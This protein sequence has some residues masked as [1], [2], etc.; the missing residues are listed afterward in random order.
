MLSEVLDCD[1]TVITAEEKATGKNVHFVDDDGRTVL[2]RFIKDP[3]VIWEKNIKQFLSGSGSHVMAD[4]VIITGGPFMHFGLGNWM[5]KRFG[6][7]VILDY[8]DPFA[9]NPIFHNSRI[10]RWVKLFFEKRFNKNCD[11][12]ITVNRYCADLI[13]GFYNKPNAII[14]NGFDERIALHSAVRRTPNGNRLIY[15]GKFYFD[16]EPLQKAT[17]NLASELVYAGADSEFLNKK[18]SNTISLGLLDHGSIFEQ[19][20]QSN[21]G[22]VQIAGGFSHLSTTKIFDYMR[23]GLRILVISEDHINKGALVEILS[24]YDN[25]CW[26]LN[27]E[28]AITSAINKLINSDYKQPDSNY[29]E[30][31]SRRSQLN[32]LVQLIND[33][34]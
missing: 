10:K 30:K 1:V 6:A 26:A 13:H 5:R 2:N 21:I 23:C 9:T 29:I 32:K 19:L 20:Q 22:V 18:Y 15:T 16:P 12:I 3:G 17:K 8:R 4:V 28:S 14:D 31:F 33:V 27:E 34:I 25:V 24:G 7:K 11:A